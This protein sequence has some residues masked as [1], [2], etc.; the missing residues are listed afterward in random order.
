MIYVLFGPP[1]VGKTYIGELLAR[2][3]DYMFFDADNIFFENHELLQMLQA[4][5]FDQEARD[6][7]F[8]KLTLDTASLLNGSGKGLVIAQAFLKEK[9]RKEFKKYF[10]GK[11]SYIR[12]EAS[13]SMAKK[14][15]VVR[16]RETQH[17]VTTSVFDT[18]WNEFEPPEV[19]HVKLSNKNTNRSQEQ[20]LV[21][22]RKIAS[23]IE[24]TKGGK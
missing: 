13:K 12:I 4:G 22:F 20:L 14:R 15:V 6:L 21:A 2:K 11:V 9:N 24:T 5:E 3:L 18:A 17:V 7:F 19:S 16:N 23:K 10:S 8:E 1:G